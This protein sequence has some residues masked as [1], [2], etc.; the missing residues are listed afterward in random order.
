MTRKR[1]CYENATC[2]QGD[3]FGT[4]LMA[5]EDPKLKPP[6]GPSTLGPSG[7]DS[8]PS[9]SRRVP[10]PGPL[11]HQIG[12]QKTPKETIAPPSH[13][14]I[15]GQVQYDEDYSLSAALESANDT[16]MQQLINIKDDAYNRL[17][18]KYKR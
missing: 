15:T 17:E 2:R 16:Y 1:S 18:S 13:W 8:G 4:D 12:S 10:L 7:S 11:S 3:V 14:P 5:C 9:K 6:R